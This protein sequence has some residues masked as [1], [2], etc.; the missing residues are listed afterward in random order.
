MY[1]L[2]MY[3]CIPLLSVFVFLIK[4]KLVIQH[5]LKAGEAFRLY[6]LFSCI[7]SDNVCHIYLCL[8]ILKGSLC[9]LSFFLSSLLRTIAGICQ[10]TV[11]HVNLHNVTLQGC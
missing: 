5:S 2:D 11:H 9:S 3:I 8:F 10:E 4:I 1:T 6:R 7:P